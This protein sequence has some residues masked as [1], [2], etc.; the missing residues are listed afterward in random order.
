[1]A[2]D[3]LQNYATDLEQEVQHRTADL[4]ER[5]S[6]LLNTLQ[7]L[8]TSQ[9]YLIRSEK[10]ASLGKLVASI[11]H[12]MNTPL[13]VIRS[14]THNISTFLRADLEQFVMSLQTLDRTYYPQLLS[15]LQKILHSDDSL[16]SLSRAE[17]RQ[18]RQDISQ[19]LSGF[20]VS[21]PDHLATMLVEL[22]IGGKGYD[23]NRLERILKRQDLND[24]NYDAMVS[25]LYHV[26]T[27]QQSLQ[28]IESATEAAEGVIQALRLYEAQ[29]SK[30]AFIWV[31][32]VESL[33]MSLKLY[34]NL[35][36]RGVSVDRHYGEVPLVWGSP[37]ELNQVWTHLLNNA[38]QSMNC[39]GSLQIEI[40]MR[41]A[42]VVVTIANDGP[43]I[44]P[45][46]VPHLF[47]P[48]FT[49]RPPG[50]GKGMGL[51]IVQRIVEKHY[52]HVE[53]VEAEF[54]FTTRFMVALPTDF[55]DRGVVL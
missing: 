22:G 36:R 9:D 28:A 52:G 16:G 47:E 40:Q 25:A 51:T 34:E 49:T 42:E 20:N 54:P 21:Q 29:E 3:R 13:G 8:Q 11:A 45:D 10:L 14:S 50:E 55:R 2:R 46:V 5:N 39:Q 12:E 43:P 38:L 41:A 35:L 48:F 27:S 6:E 1:V 18:A 24:F 44:P 33:E 32:L 53:L 4:T 17:R 7:D 19:F 23:W 31:N 26:S 15:F 37:Q 30:G